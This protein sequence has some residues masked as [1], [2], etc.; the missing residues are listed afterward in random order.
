MNGIRITEAKVATVINAVLKTKET[1]GIKAKETIEIKATAMVTITK[2]TRPETNHHL[3]TTK[4]GLNLIQV[5]NRATAA[6]SAAK[7][8]N[9][10]TSNP[11]RKQSTVTVTQGTARRAVTLRLKERGVTPSDPSTVPV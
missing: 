11:E 4:P 9:N 2:A 6:N 5:N 1:M 8:T 3:P 10:K 7:L